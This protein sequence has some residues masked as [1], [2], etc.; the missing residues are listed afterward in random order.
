MKQYTSHDLTL[1]HWKTHS[2]FSVR[3]YIVDV[4]D[5]LHIA[6]SKQLLFVY[7]ITTY[8]IIGYPPPPKAWLMVTVTV[9]GRALYSLQLEVSTMTH[10]WPW[11][12]LRNRRNSSSGQ[13]IRG[14]IFSTSFLLLLAC[15]CA[16][17]L[18]LFIPKTVIPNLLL[19]SVKYFNSVSVWK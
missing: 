16:L 12:H 11:S 18:S 4:T 9:S 10:T 17:Y 7:I 2:W 19:C 6:E 5:Q 1:Q 3:H 8:Y 15:F 14:V 13:T